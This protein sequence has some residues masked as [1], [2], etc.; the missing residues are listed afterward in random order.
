MLLFAKRRGLPG[1]QG[2]KLFA[3][4]NQIQTGDQYAFELIDDKRL[5]VSMMMG[6]STD[7]ESS[8]GGAFPPVTIRSA[9]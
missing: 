2:W 6:G 7:S 1:L 9:C 4:A 5:V 3:E 8:S